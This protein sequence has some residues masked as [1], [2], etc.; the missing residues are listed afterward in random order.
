MVSVTYTRQTLSYFYL[1]FPKKK[2]KKKRSS[3]SYK[4]QLGVRE[5]Y[6]SFI[7]GFSVYLSRNDDEE[8]RTEKVEKG[9]KVRRTLSSLRNRMT[10][11]FNKDKVNSQG[12]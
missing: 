1:S 7:F 12:W 10:G 6:I 3:I 8:D 2:K 4:D 9:T 5:C 11:S